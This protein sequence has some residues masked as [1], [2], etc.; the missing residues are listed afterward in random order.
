[1]NSILNL[2]STWTAITFLNSIEHSFSGFIVDWYGSLNEDGKN[3]LRMMETPAAMFKN[4]DS[5]E[6]TRE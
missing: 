1:M 5:K 6:K 3:T 4:L 2:N